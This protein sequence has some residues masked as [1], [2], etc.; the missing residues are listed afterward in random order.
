MPK[1]AGGASLLIAVMTETFPYGTMMN[2]EK[3]VYLKCILNTY[4]LVIFRVVVEN[5]LTSAS[6]IRSLLE[7]RRTIGYAGVGAFC[8]FTLLF[9]Q[10]IML[11]GP[12][13]INVFIVKNKNMITEMFKV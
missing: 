5:I 4:N 2:A 6:N 1:W 11:V 13:L 12:T 8:I 10:T 7:A 3:L 9:L